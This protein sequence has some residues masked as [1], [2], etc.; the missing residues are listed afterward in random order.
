MIEN[1]WYRFDIL[2]NRGIVIG[3]TKR[4]G[5][6]H[7]P[8]NNNNNGNSTS[9]SYSNKLASLYKDNSHMLSLNWNKPLFGHKHTSLQKILVD[10]NKA[11]EK[12]TKFINKIKSRKW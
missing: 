10:A 6:Y 11:I 3:N 7:H 4:L 8:T 12:S 5:R 9:P 1:V 2:F